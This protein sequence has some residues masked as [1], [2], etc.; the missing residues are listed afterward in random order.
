MGE[1]A[2]SELYADTKR[3]REV[4]TEHRQLK[5]TLEGLYEDWS[6]LIEEAEEV[7]L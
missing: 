3:S 2:T 4:V 5:S 1:L 6:G 7:N